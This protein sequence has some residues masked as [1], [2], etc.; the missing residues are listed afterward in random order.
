MPR[1][2]SCGDRRRYNGC[3]S[4]RKNSDCKP[5]ADPDRGAGVGG[6]AVAA[7]QA[8][9]VQGGP[10]RDRRGRR[11]A[12]CGPRRGSARPRRPH[13]LRRRP[14]RGGHARARR[15]D[16][17]H[18]VAPGGLQSEP[19]GGPADAAGSRGS[20]R[21]AAG[22]PDPGRCGLAVLGRSP[23]RG[24]APRSAARGDSGCT[25]WSSPRRSPGWARRWVTRG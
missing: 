21:L 12:A 14:W 1:Q 18:G 23:E 11:D 19:A 7:A 4:K 6:A 10:P 15:R 25:A 3:L 22:V 24:G 17:V 20:R 2:P 8:R 13:R 9:R 16:P 5:P